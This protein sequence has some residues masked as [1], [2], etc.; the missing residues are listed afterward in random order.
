MAERRT[1]R[2]RGKVDYIG[3]RG[4]GRIDWRLKYRL[5]PKKN[6][7]SSSCIGNLPCKPGYNLINP[8]A[9]IKWLLA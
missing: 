5:L 4:W 1:S 2:K 6:T 3:I 8:W 7:L 9:E